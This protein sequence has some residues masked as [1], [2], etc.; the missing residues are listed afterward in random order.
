MYFLFVP[1]MIKDRLSLT[2]TVGGRCPRIS[3]DGRT[4]MHMPD[5]LVKLY[6]LDRYEDNRKALQ[7]QGVSIQPAMA[8]DLGR[9]QRWITEHFGEGREIL[10]FAYYDATAKDFF[11]P[12]GVDE[13]ARGLGVGR[14]LL[15]ATLKSMAANG[16]VYAIIGGAGPVKFY[17][18]CCGAAVIEGSS[19]GYYRNLL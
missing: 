2:G 15:L 14:A 17:E 12:T 4:V 16:Y 8:A 18:T 13:A 19:P 11:G 9:V 7:T 6:E 3:A 5:M 10:G 1:V